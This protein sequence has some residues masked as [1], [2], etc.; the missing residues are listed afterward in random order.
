METTAES[1]VTE[2]TIIN[3]TVA[4]GVSQP[5][6]ER[7]YGL[8]AQERAFEKA[9]FG[10]MAILLTIQ[11]CLGAIACMFVS[12]DGSSITLLAI[13]AAVTMGSNALFIALA[14]PRLCLFGFYLSIILNTALIIVT[15]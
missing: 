1:T 10:W 3:E 8:K 5:L 15:M 13:G 12:L 4:A 6:T 7:W 9:R 14:S 2:Q 11:S